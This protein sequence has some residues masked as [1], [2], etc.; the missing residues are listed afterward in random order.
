MGGGLNCNDMPETLLGGVY[1]D[2]MELGEVMGLE[3]RGLSKT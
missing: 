1:W 3:S 2:F